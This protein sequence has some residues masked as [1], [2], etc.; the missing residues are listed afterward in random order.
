[1]GIGTNFAVRLPELREK[2]KRGIEG[3]GKEKEEKRER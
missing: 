2:K 3:K 1:M